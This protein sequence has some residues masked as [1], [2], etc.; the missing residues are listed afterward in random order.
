MN[1]PRG[2]LRTDLFRIIEDYGGQM[3]LDI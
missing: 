3:R 1:Q 2:A